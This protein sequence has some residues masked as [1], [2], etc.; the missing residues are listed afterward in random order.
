[1]SSFNYSDYQNVVNAAQNKGSNV[2]VGFFKLGSDGAE[3]L[4]RINVSSLDDLEF[5]TVHTVSAGGKWLRVSCLNEVGSYSDDCELCAANTAGD[6]RVSKAAKK[7]F[8]Q[9]LVSYKDPTTGQFSVPIPVIWERPAGFSRE[10]AN[11]LRDYGNLRDVLLKV[12]RNGA[13]NDMKTTYSL[14]YAVPT[15]YK[16]E[17]IPA[18]FSAFNNFKINK[19]S[20]WEKTAEEIHTFITTGAFPEVVKTGD[21]STETVVVQQTVATK[22]AVYTAPY[23]A[24]TQPAYTTVAAEP[25]KPAEQPAT[26]PT[27]SFG[28]G[29]FPK[30]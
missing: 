8:V 14:D 16:P 28:D 18:D 1:M 21:V 13:A 4:V 17:M 27:T 23:A 11:K 10:I 5:A 9:M 3:A 29:F 22:Q 26:K 24:P 30:F 6:Q 20:Y 2:K 19:H 7:V 15:V 12:T 25:T